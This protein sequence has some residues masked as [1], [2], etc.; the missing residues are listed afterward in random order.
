VTASDIHLVADGGT[1][2]G[3]GFG[4]F[5]VTF[6]PGEQ[7]RTINI[8]PASDRVP[9]PDEQ[10]SVTLTGA[11]FG[12]L[13]TTAPIAR[14]V[15]IVNDD[16]FPEVFFSVAGSPSGPEGN[17]PFLSAIPL[18]LSRVGDLSF[19]TE[20][21]FSV[22]GIGTATA[23]DVAFVADGGTPVGSGFGSFTVTF[24]PGEQS[25]TINIVP[26]SDRVP[27]PDEQVSVTLTGAAFGTLS[28]TAPIARTVTIVND[29]VFPTVVIAPNGP[30]SVTEGNAG[31]GGVVSIVIGRVGDL[32]Y[33]TEVTFSVAGLGGTTADDIAFV[34]S[35]GTPIGSG[36]GS[37]AITFAPGEQ[38]RIINIVASG[39]AAFEPD[40]SFLVTLLGADRGTLAT[41]GPLSVTGTFLNDDAFGNAAP[42][43]IALTNASVLEALPAGTLVGLLSATDADAGETFAF[44]FAPGAPAGGNAGGLFRIDGNRLLT[45]AALDHEAA[46]T[47]GITLRVTDSAGNTHDEAFTIAVGNVAEGGPGDPVAPV[48]INGPGFSISNGNTGTPA[49][50]TPGGPALGTGTLSGAVDTAPIT[51]AG[52]VT[53]ARIENEESWNGLKNLVLGPAFWSPALG[54]DVLVANFVDVRWD[55]STA[56]AL[57]FDLLIVGA[58]RGAVTLAGGDDVLT[59]AFH[60]NEGVWANTATVAGGAGNDTLA[61]T[62]T[63]L[64]AVDDALLADNAEPANGPLWNPGYDGRFSTAL[65]DGGAGDDVITAAARVRLVAD[66]GVGDDALEGGARNDVL[67]GGDGNDVLTGGLGGDRFVFDATDGADAIID[68]SRAQG[69]RVVLEGPGTLAF[70]G[71]GF[72]FGATSVTATNGHAWSAADFLFA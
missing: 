24:E 23:A 65:A 51:L 56:P 53:R 31:P 38:A 25:R 8:V 60:S 34:A 20:V 27:E 17:P 7:S 3:S 45:D 12:T 42:S 29:D 66:G 48:T 15:T 63:G 68:F 41:T 13:S 47:R 28:T 64:S 70:S 57:D 21:T 18:T 62:A 36:F 26:A 72:T 33:E 50:A 14:T 43:D 44:S 5:T 6:E 10:V 37:F 54:T 32:G 49:T 35:G 2:V 16:V 39:D 22:A 9:E 11:A 4:S 40:E 69:D 19:A 58:K 1:P 59:W 55:L 71:T 52:D 46:A 61:F 67:R 30:P